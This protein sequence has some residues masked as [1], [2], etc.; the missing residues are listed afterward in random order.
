MTCD[1]SG[2]G[3]EAV[4]VGRFRTAE[5]TA[6]EASFTD[7]VLP[8]TSFEKLDEV[9][10]ADS[11][12]PRDSNDSAGSEADEGGTVGS[13]NTS[14]SG[15]RRQTGH[16]TGR[17]TALPFHVNPALLN[18]ANVRKSWGPR[19]RLTKI[20]NLYTDIV[21][22]LVSLSTALSPTVKPAP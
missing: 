21:S 17:G 15:V 8:S 5:E 2:L 14:D 20:M 4:C 3:E 19:A 13:G 18:I 7:D 16:R 6:T 22:P 12:S 10:G 9:G 1:L 11:D